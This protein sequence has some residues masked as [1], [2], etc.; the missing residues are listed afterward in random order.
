MSDDE[1]VPDVEEEDEDASPRTY[2]ASDEQLEEARR[3]NEARRALLQVDDEEVKEYWESR[4]EQRDKEEEE[5]TQLKAKIEQRRIERIAEDKKRRQREKEEDEH[6]AEIEAEKKA[7]KEAEEEERRA[8]RD[9]ARQSDKSSE[10]TGKRNFVIT[11]K[12]GTKVE[13]SSQSADGEPVQKTKEQLE[14]EKKAALAQ[15]IVP[16]DVD[17]IS[18]ADLEAKAKE[19]HSKWFKL[20]GDKYDLEQEHKRKQYDLMELAE[21]ARQVNK[22]SG[23]GKEHETADRMNDKHVNAP[24]KVTLCSK[25]DRH[26]DHRTYSERMQFF[27]AGG[28]KAGGE[29]KGAIKEEAEPEEE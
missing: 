2:A 21:R 15:R 19:L 1:E 20:E 5:I 29:A 10:N 11:K 25:F 4:M 3:V 9:A 7:R 6:R 8:K 23:G 17:S 27:L 24:A 18:D 28:D 12:D 16:V 14:A 26:T 13:T 22:G